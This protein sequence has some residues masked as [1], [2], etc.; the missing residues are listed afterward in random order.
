MKENLSIIITS[1]K[2]DQEQI[3]MNN[4]GNNFIINLMPLTSFS[5]TQ[6]SDSAK[7]SSPE[8][9]K[10]TTSTPNNNVTCANFASSLPYHFSE[11]EN[12]YICN[13]CNCTYDSLR[14]IKAHLW[15]HS[16]HHELSYPIHDYN[17]R[18]KFFL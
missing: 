11:F 16:G 7:S 5:Q 12:L 9:F 14:S 2:I 18:C 1:D 4:I 13:L 10:L 17:N 3:N 6:I 15:K 8:Y